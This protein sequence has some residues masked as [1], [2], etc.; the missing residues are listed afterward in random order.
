MGEWLASSRV[1]YAC[2]GDTDKQEDDGYNKPIR[3]MIKRLRLNKPQNSK[4][5]I[6]ETCVENQ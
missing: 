6:S 3:I 2:H 4:V 5:H 1:F